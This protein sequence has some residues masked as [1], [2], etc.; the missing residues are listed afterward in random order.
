[1]PR[2]KR[3]TPRD[4]S[5]RDPEPVQDFEKLVSSISDDGTTLHRNTPSRNSCSTIPKIS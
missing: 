4:I 3:E 1:M 5:S 2:K